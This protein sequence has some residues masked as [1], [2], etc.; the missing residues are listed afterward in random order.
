MLVLSRSILKIETYLIFLKIINF[1]SV[2]KFSGL[3]CI[4]VGKNTMKY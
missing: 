3:L 1:E 4:A 2:E